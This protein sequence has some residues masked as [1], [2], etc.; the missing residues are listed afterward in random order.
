M[1]ALRVNTQDQIYE[2]YLIPKGTCIIANLWCVAGQ[3]R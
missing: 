1:L 3:Q 2:G